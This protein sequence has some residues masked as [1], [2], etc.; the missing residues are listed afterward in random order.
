M[1]T[2]TRDE[3]Q[4]TQM[5]NE[6]GFKEINGQ[7]NPLKRTRPTRYKSRAVLKTKRLKDL[8][9]KDQKTKQLKAGAVK[10]KTPKNAEKS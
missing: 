6:F 2:H 9:T 10:Q 3:T 7:S 8:K 1:K 4:D 5:R